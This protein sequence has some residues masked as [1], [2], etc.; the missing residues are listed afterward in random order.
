M[1]SVFWICKYYYYYVKL[2]PPIGIPN[3][4]RFPSSSSSLV[5]CILTSIDPLS[6]YTTNQPPSY[7]LLHTHIQEPKKNNHMTNGEIF[8]MVLHKILS[9]SLHEYAYVTQR[10]KCD[11]LK[12]VQA[13]WSG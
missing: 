2:F 7:A 5:L 11:N 8:A 4:P 10:V 12:P 1:Y 13:D 3:H 9:F 6:N